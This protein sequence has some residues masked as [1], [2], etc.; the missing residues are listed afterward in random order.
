VTPG[1]NRRDNDPSEIR[2]ITRPFTAAISLAFM[3]TVLTA[4][5]GL[6]VDP[7]F[8]SSL[9][10]LD[11]A[12]RLEQICDYEAMDR[13]SHG[14]GGFRPD[15][16]KSDVVTAPDHLGDLLVGKGGA[17]RSA[18]HWYQFSFKCR[19]SPDH[20][21]VLSFDYRVGSMIPES[22]WNTYG[23]WR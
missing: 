1:F 8:I 19:A 6:A 4:T 16:A 20:L 2:F 21:K 17:F 7:R 23:L 3:A 22:K 5:P 13:I 10:R 15:R 9:G 12:T 14:S 18:G 11:A